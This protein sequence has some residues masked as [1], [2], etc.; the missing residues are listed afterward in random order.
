MDAN[1]EKM[2]EAVESTVNLNSVYGCPVALDSPIAILQR[3]IK[4]TTEPPKGLRANM[5]TLFNTI[6]E[7]QFA[8]CGQQSTYKKLLFH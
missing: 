3:G 4:M 1:T 7:E 5:M 2:I 8:R 6:G